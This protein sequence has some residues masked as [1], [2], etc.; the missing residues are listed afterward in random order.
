M[1]LFPSPST[2]KSSFSKQF[3]VGSS[4]ED[5]AESAVKA[6][7]AEAAKVAAAVK[8]K[9]QIAL[10]TAEYYQYCTLGGILGK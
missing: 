1:A 5:K 7:E 3:F 8:P 9:K 10:Y 6:V 4:L 2:L